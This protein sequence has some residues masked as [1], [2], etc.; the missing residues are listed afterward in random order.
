M[1]ICPGKTNLL[2]LGLDFA[3]MRSGES[4]ATETSS[5]KDRSRN[6]RT[7]PSLF[8]C[9]L[10]VGDRVVTPSGREAVVRELGSAIA[11][12]YFT[13]ENRLWWMPIRILKTVSV[14]DLKQKC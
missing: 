4:S 2:Q 7:R 11:L 13:K 9:H 12:C 8:Q 14:S 10:K 1:A 5:D 3:Q 6:S